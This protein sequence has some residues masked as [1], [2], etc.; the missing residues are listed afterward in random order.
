MSARRSNRSLQPSEIL[1]LG[2]IDAAPLRALF[3][4]FGVNLHRV[5]HD[6]S[7]AGSYWG[8]PEAGIVGR[9]V[10]AR[11]DT[12]VHSVL[13]ELCHIVCMTE[14]RRSTLMRDAGAG[15]EEECAVCLLQLLLA[16]CLP[17][18]GRERLMR[19]MDAWGYSFR[20]GSTNR[21]FTEDTHDTRRWLF[22]KDLVAQ[23]G[24]CLFRLRQA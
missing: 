18:V 3:D 4:R 2:G 1:C 17:D 15:D 13:H 20:L 10:H 19:D 11:G 6:Q 7:I 5:A 8:E 14:E 24:T 22:D 16:D 23:D 21:W 12:P 9:T